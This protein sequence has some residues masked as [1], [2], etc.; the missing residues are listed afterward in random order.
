MHFF[1]GLNILLALAT[2]SNGSSVK[3]TNEV[4]IT[5]LGAANAQFTQNFP[6]DGSIV[7][8]SN[9]LSISHVSSAD[10]N[11]Q[12]TFHGID[13]SVTTVSGAQLVDVGPPQTQ[14]SG[15]CS[16]KGGSGSTS[17]PSNPSNK[18]HGEPGGQNEHSSQVQVVFIGAANAEFTQTFP[19]NG[20]AMQI[21]NVLS[22][23][24]IELNTASVM[25]TFHGID[26]GVTTVSGNELVD[27]GPPQTQV[28]GSCQSI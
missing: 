24:H 19:V 16:V 8:I 14:I 10:A 18:E 4:E 25:C 23:S 21:T 20:Q 26:N 27:V 3:R 22:I 7:S 11:I 15:S 28:W 6:V 5:F 9:V 12:C 17:S 2:A 1:T 13:N